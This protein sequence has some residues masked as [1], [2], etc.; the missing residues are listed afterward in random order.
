LI[1]LVKEKEMIL[2]KKRK[3]AIKKRN[4]TLSLNNFGSFSASS[5]RYFR[6]VLNAISPTFNCFPHLEHFNF[7]A[8]TAFVDLA[9]SVVPFCLFRLVLVHVCDNYFSHGLSLR[10]INLLFTRN[11]NFSF[12]FG[13]Y[14]NVG[15][16]SMSSIT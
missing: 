12:D 3:V 15:S 11:G 2:K 8:V 6:L 14:S 9:V 5:H 10:I 1:S 4:R 16:K 13:G 7:S